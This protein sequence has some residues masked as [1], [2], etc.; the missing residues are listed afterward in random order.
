MEKMLQRAGFGMVFR[1]AFRKSRHCPAAVL[2]DEKYE[3]ES[4]YVEA[5]KSQP[6]QQRRPQ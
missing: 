3:W 6:E 1:A 2:D 5:V 4:L